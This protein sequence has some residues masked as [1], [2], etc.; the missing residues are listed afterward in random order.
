MTLKLKVKVWYRNS[1]L[2]NYFSFGNSDL[3][4]TVIYDGNENL[5]TRIKTTRALA[6]FFI[7][8]K[9]MNFY[10]P[11]SIQKA[12]RLI[13]SFELQRDPKLKSKLEVI[14]KPGS[15]SE[16]LVYFLRIFFSMQISLNTY[17][18]HRQVKKWDFHLHKI[19]VTKDCH[20]TTASNSL[21]VLTMVVTN[22]FPTEGNDIIN[23]IA[24]FF[25]AIEDNKNLDQFFDET[26][27]KNFYLIFFP[28]FFCYKRLS[29]SFE[30]EFQIEI[31]LKQA[32]WEIWAMMTQPW[33]FNDNAGLTHLTNLKEFIHDLPI[34]SGTLKIESIEL[35]DTIN[36]YTFFISEQIK[37]SK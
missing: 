37:L 3:D 32:S 29:Y 10:Y 14:H 12:S 1:L 9:E 26:L 6:G 33:I 16:K 27:S 15:N 24:I 13:N 36:E 31:L 28:H 21:D 18:S 23:N 25:Q 30:N 20:V 8:I 19:L 11:F 22:F 7:I 34:V 5:L 35:V 2:E 4:L 17:F